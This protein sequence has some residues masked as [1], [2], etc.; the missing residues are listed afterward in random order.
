MKF[1]QNQLLRMNGFT[2]AEEKGEKSP[3]VTVSKRREI[4]YARHIIILR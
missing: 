1:M 3:D 2:L 4:H